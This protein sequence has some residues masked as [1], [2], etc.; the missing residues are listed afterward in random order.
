MTDVNPITNLPDPTPPSAPV[1]PAPVELPTE[2]TPSA[3]VETDLPTDLPL[4]PTP[5]AT[6]VDSTSVEALA[7][8][9]AAAVPT[10]SA[11]LPS[12]GNTAGGDSVVITGTGFTGVEGDG[13][14]KFGTVEATS[15]VVDSDTQLTVVVPAGAAGTVDIT[16][17]NPNGPFTFHNAYTYDVTAATAPPAV[18]PAASET[19]NPADSTPATPTAP[20]LPTDGNYSTEQIAAAEALGLDTPAG[21]ALSSGSLEILRG[22]EKALAGIDSWLAHAR[23]ILGSLPEKP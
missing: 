20:L 14:V 8:T 11:V 17:I 12:T 21:R 9:A 22:M 15:Y 19:P 5:P 3:P 6:P 2:L 7:A 18:T 23:R 10:I 1:D 13:S 4:A 16:I